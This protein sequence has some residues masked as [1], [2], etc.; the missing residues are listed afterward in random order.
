MIKVNQTRFGGFDSPIEELGNC[1]QACLA[2]ILEIPL[3]E[4]FD[5]V[6]FDLP[7]EGSLFEKQPWYVTFN[8]WLAKYGL[9]SIYLEWKP[10]AP[11]ITE[12]LGYHIADIKSSTL[13]NG[14]S[15]SV[16][17]HNGELAHD[18]NPS[19]KVNGDDLLGIYLIV[20]LDVAKLRKP[21]EVMELK[22]KEE[23]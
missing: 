7:K 1:F 9:G 20:P 15:H 17:I 22:Y 3:R 19:S 13:S 4:A 6:T 16:V 8:E 11:A 21:Q 2:S 10:T 5:C 14:E 23:G 12:L 18:P